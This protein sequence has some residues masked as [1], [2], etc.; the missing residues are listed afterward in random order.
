MGREPILSKICI[1][2]NVQEN[3]ILHKT[4][5]FGK[6]CR[7]LKFLTAEKIWFKKNFFMIDQ[8]VFV[9][10]TQTYATEL[11]KWTIGSNKLPYTIILNFSYTITLNFSWAFYFRE[12]SVKQKLKVQK[13]QM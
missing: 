2:A 7:N 3:V 6:T 5:Y 8:V 9:P 10:G 12:C 11:K 1:T 13:Y 4:F